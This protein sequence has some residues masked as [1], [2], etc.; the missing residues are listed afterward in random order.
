MRQM[1]KMSIWERIKMV[2]GMGKAGA[3]QPGAKMLK[4]KGDTGHRKS[5]QGTGRRN[6]RRNA[7]RR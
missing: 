2:T 4:N 3:F 6:A 7:R 5:R 1:A